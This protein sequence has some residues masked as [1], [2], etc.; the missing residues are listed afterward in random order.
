MTTPLQ[1]ARRARGWSQ[2]RAVSELLRLARWKRIGVASATSLKT[3]LS[4]WENGHVTPD[5]YQ[6]LLCEVYR[7]TPGELGFGIQELPNGSSKEHS[8]G[9]ALIAKRE[10][11][12]DDI[13]SLSSSFDE[14][15]SHCPK[16]SGVMTPGVRFPSL[17]NELAAG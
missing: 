3:Q 14:A 5:Y 11:N 12:R 13:S 16:V 6:G 7:S 1:T 15:I 8:Q 2:A 10:W 9:T 4:R 17:G